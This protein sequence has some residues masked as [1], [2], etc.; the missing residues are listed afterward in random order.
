LQFRDEPGEWE[1]IATDAGDSRGDQAF[2]T[3]I[4]LASW[5]LVLRRL[6]KRFPHVTLILRDAADATIFRAGRGG[7]GESEL[8]VQNLTLLA[9]VPDPDAMMHHLKTRASLRLPLA[10]LNGVCKISYPPASNPADKAPNLRFSFAYSRYPPLAA[11]A[12]KKVATPRS[13]DDAGELALLGDQQ[14]QQRTTQPR[15]PQPK[16]AA[17]AA[18]L[19]QI[20]TEFRI[21]GKAQDPGVSVEFVDRF[22]VVTLKQYEARRASAEE[23][24]VPPPP[25]NSGEKQRKRPRDEEGGGGADAPSSQAPSLETGHRTEVILLTQPAQYKLP[26]MGD[27]LMSAKLVQKALALSHPLPAPAVLDFTQFGDD[28]ECGPLLFRLGNQSGTLT[29]RAFVAS[30]LSEADGGVADDDDD[31]VPPPVSDD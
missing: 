23:P 7:N 6:A 21:S 3:M 27:M 29:I 28:G 2:D 16:P 19:G 4:K 12:A 13:A 25:P 24:E 17:V 26:K 11:P 8:I 30:R 5:K 9:E 10:E 1:E 18:P 15:P 22:K 14:Q 31:E 20:E